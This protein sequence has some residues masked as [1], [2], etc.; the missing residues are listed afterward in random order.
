MNILKTSLALTAILMLLNNCSKGEQQNNDLSANLD[1]VVSSDTSPLPPGT[2]AFRLFSEI[3]E[4]ISESEEETEDT[5]TSEQVL[6]LANPQILTTKQKNKWKETFRKCSKTISTSEVNE[7]NIVV[8][9][10]TNCA[11][12]ILNTEHKK[13]LKKLDTLKANVTTAL[14]NYI[15]KTEDKDLPEDKASNKKLSRKEFFNKIISSTITTL[16][17]KSDSTIKPSLLNKISKRIFKKLKKTFRKKIS[18]LEIKETTEVLTKTISTNIKQSDI[19]T[20]ISEFMTGASS[21]IEKSESDISEEEKE[22]FNVDV[23]EYTATASLNSTYTS[24]EIKETIIVKL[25]EK[26]VKR[27]IKKNKNK[28]KNKSNVEKLKKRLDK[29]NRR[30]LNLLAKNKANKKYLKIYNSSFSASLKAARKEKKIDNDTLVEATNDRIKAGFEET[31]DEEAQAEITD[32]AFSILEDEDIIKNPEEVSENLTE[33]ILEAATK[34]AKKAKKKKTNLSNALKSIT[35][36]KNKLA[37]N[38]RIKKKSR[39]YTAKKAIKILREEDLQLAKEYTP[40]II[41]VTLAGQKESTEEQANTPEQREAAETEIVDDILE[42]FG[43]DTK[44]Q[45]DIMEDL[46][47][48]SQ[49]EDQSEIEGEIKVEVEMK[50]EVEADSEAGA[51]RDTHEETEATEA[52]T[53]ATTI[54]TE[55]EGAEKN[56]APTAIAIKIKPTKKQKILSQKEKLKDLTKKALRELEK[57][58]QQETE[59]KKIKKKEPKK[60]E[61]KKKEP[62]KKEP[63]KKNKKTNKP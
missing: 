29:A 33:T 26:K 20:L 63:K 57:K 47:Q 62:K 54:A 56:T 25:T 21:G 34:S 3:K 51:M 1:Q 19:P 30:L 2:H 14:M 60:K 31:D 5:E 12:D 53:P 17:K 11:Y 45:I 39:S 35:K 18:S 43:D 32:Q 49:A 41:S 46:I 52:T 24:D 8:N 7:Y 59:E 38:K 48:Q 13:D 50:V 61:P 27:I 10:L 36:N 42:M 22:Q 58:K 55:A 6:L 4:T 40:D 15:G 37:K 28:N 44:D 9:K 23:F 16:S